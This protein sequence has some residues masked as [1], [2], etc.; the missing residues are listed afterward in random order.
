MYGLKQAPRA[1]YKRLTI[2]FLE[3]SFTRRGSDKTL[4]IKKDTKHILIAQN[5]C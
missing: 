4:F 3:S 5:I 1:W 2:F